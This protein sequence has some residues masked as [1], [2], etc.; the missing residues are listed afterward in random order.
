VSRPVVHRREPLDIRSIRAR[1][2]EDDTLGIALLESMIKI[3]HG[4][5]PIAHQLPGDMLDTS[6]SES[7][8]TNAQPRLRASET[9][10]FLAAVFPDTA[11]I[12]L[13]RKRLDTGLM[14]GT[15]EAARRKPRPVR[16]G[17]QARISISIPEAPISARLM[18]DSE[19]RPE[20]ETDDEDE[21]E[22]RMAD[23]RAIKARRQ[24]G[25]D[26]VCSFSVGRYRHLCN[27]STHPDLDTGSTV[28]NEWGH[29]VGETTLAIH[30]KSAD[31]LR[32]LVGIGNMPGVVHLNYVHPGPPH[33]IPLDN[34]DIQHYSRVVVG[35]APGVSM[36]VDPTPPHRRTT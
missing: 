3:I 6:P 11:N 27:R 8:R 31:P 16:G 34:Q 21:D 25:P 33:Q 17:P 1:N 35:F 7:H 32:S 19:I 13:Y 24:A 4:N 2:Y 28:C 12:A 9:Y 29:A 22:R 18:W 20:S 5:I 23:G 10:D 36:P 26:I 30:R 15:R 14:P